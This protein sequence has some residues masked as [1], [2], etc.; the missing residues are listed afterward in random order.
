MA[1]DRALWKFRS[2]ARLAGVR[3]YGKEQP[4]FSGRTWSMCVRSRRCAQCVVDEFRGSWAEVRIRRS[5]SFTNRY[6]DPSMAICNIDVRSRRAPLARR[7]AELVLFAALTSCTATMQKP[8]SPEAQAAI[9]A[10]PPETPAPPSED[11]L[12]GW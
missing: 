4:I 7:A 9:P 5:C 12:A 3:H 8:A 2:E 1:S 11:T 6:T 10:T